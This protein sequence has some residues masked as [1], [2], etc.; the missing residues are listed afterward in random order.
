MNFSSKLTLES[1]AQKPAIRLKKNDSGLTNSEIINYMSVLSE[2]VVCEK[3][4]IQRSYHLKGYDQ[5]IALVNHIAQIAKTN[6]HHP[7]VSFDYNSCAVN[8]STH[9]INGLTEN[10]FICAAQI[11]IK[12]LNLGESYS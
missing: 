12:F 5:T 6:D 3:N 8:Y 9:V 7:E 1:I 4:S 2:W 11:E 10:D